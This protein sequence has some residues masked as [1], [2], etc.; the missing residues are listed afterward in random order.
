MV[1][2]LMYIARMPQ[3][4]AISITPEA[5]DIDELGHVSNLV[6]LRWVLD[7]AMAHTRA[8]GWDYEQYRAL[9]AIFMVRRHEIDYIAQVTVGQVLR[10]ETWVDTWRAASC[11]RKTELIRD[12]VVVARAATT[13]AMI[14][15][16]SGR[17][18]RIPSELTAL[19]A[20]G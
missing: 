8:R 16:A 17:P 4:F 1:S 10:A 2:R 3:R 13:W 5:S 18:Q 19:F 9:G 20:S 7:V 11:I 14:G 12:G 15:L 6:Y